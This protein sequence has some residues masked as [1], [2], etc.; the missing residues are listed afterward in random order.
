MANGSSTLRGGNNS[1]VPMKVLIE[2]PVRF[3]ETRSIK[4][5][6]SDNGDGKDDSSFVKFEIKL[7]G[8]DDKPSTDKYSMFIAVIDFPKLFPEAYCLWRKQLDELFRAKGD[9][10]PAQRTATFA[11]CTTGKMNAFFITAINKRTKEARKKKAKFIN[12][13]AS[14]QS[15]TPGT[16]TKNNIGFRCANG[17]NSGV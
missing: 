10:S 9:Q 3:K 6:K 8:D 12:N 4:K 2:A 11:G 1:S 5:K 15:M 13:Q 14:R 7:I 16:T 17:A